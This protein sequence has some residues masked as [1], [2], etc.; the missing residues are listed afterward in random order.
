LGGDCLDGGVDL[1]YFRFRVVWNIELRA[2][3]PHKSLVTVEPEEW[4]VAGTT[5]YL[6]RINHIHLIIRYPVD[7]ELAHDFIMG[8]YQAEHTTESLM[9]SLA[10]WNHL[11]DTTYIDLGW[12]GP[13][14]FA[15]MDQW[16]QEG[17]PRGR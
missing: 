16:K 2:G 1:V 12:H 3:F 15:K 11:Q 7:D 10:V 8:K 4:L 9:A 17:L 14:D 13:G 5:V 6:R